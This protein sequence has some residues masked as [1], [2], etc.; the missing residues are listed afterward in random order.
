VLRDAA[1]GWP[2]AGVAERGNLAN[3]AKLLGTEVGLEVTSKCI[4][5]VGG[6]GAYRDYPVERAFRDARTA[7]LM[8][9]TMDRMAELIGK[10]ALG[11]TEGM[12]RISGAPGD[13]TA[14]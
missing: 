14:T 13:A 11:L 3:R 10:S 9:P 1:A 4:Q 2:T 5:V 7:T 6:R 12:F 8:P